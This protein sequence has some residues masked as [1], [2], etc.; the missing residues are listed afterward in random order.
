M[1]TLNLISLLIQQKA[2]WIPARLFLAIFGNFKIRG[3]E[4]LKEINRNAIFACNHASEIDIFLLPAAIPFWSHFSPMFYTSRESGFY[5]GSGWRRHFYGGLLFK[6]LG[7]YPVTVDLRNYSKA[8]S[9]QIHIVNDGRSLCIFP[10]GQTTPNG[11][12]QRAKGGVVYLAY[13]TN[14]PIVPVRLNGTFHFSIKDFFMRKTKLSVS[15]GK[16]I[17]LSAQNESSIPIGECKNRANDIMNI[18]K[19]MV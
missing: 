3:L 12:I 13:I 8:L 11:I 4:N 2:P 10:E 16:P 1:N 15:F 19:N 6:I 9:N 17:Y 7:S 5:G 14:V 18:I